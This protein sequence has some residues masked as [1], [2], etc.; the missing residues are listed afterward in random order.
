MNKSEFITL[1]SKHFRKRIG[2]IK[3]VIIHCSTRT[4]KDIVDL[5]DELGLS[6]HY[7][8]GRDGLVIENVDPKNVAFHAGQSSWKNSLEYSLNE[9]SI[10]IELE[11]PNMGQDK[12]DYTDIQIKKL[13]E[14][15]EYLTNLYGIDKKD[16]LGH[17]DVAPTR[18]PDPGFCFPWKYLYDNGFGVW[19]E[20]NSLYDS[21]DEKELFNIIGYD[22][23][24]LCATRYAFCR[25]FFTKEVEAFKDI[26]YLVD[27]P[28]PFDFKPN[29]FNGYMTTLKSVAKN[30]A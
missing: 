23:S 24:D 29:D 8:I 21:N 26:K 6:A 13:C 27:N 12:N 5:L 28:Y 11:A 17:S 1:H 22:T 15:L 9:C 3:Y 10:G 7:I 20:N 30:L 14:L 2:Q 16:I 18:K 25:H 19:Y 4:P